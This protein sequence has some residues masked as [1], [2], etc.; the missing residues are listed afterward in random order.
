MPGGE[1]GGGG[2]PW[3][4]WGQADR[5]ALRGRLALRPGLPGAF[6]ALVCPAFPVPWACRPPLCTSPAEA[7]GESEQWASSS[8]WGEEGGTLAE[9]SRPRLTQ[10]YSP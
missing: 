4:W 2:E 3:A 10:N 7:G 6:V 8:G 5:A 1:R 9:P